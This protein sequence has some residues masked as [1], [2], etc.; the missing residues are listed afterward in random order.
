MGERLFTHVADEMTTGDDS[1]I[2]VCQIGAEVLRDIAGT[3]QEVKKLFSYVR[4]EKE[5]PKRQ[6]MEPY[7]E[8]PTRDCSTMMTSD[9]RDKQSQIRPMS[10]PP[11]VV[12]EVRESQKQ[13][14]FAFDFEGIEFYYNGESLQAFDINENHRKLGNFAV[15]ILEEKTSVEDIVNEANEV[16]ARSERLFWGI[17]IIVGEQR[18]KG[19]IFNADLYQFRWVHNISKGRAFFDE[20]KENRRLLKIY[21][22]KQI[23]AKRYQS[24]QE[25][26]S[27]G[28]KVLEN[29]KCAYLVSDGIIGDLNMSIKA[30]DK[31]CL[32]RSQETDPRRIFMEFLEMRSVI[33]GNCGNAIF[34]QYY[35]LTALMTSLFKKTGHQIEFC[36]AVIGK[37][38]TRKT[39]CAEIFTRV[40]NRT[41][42]AVPDIN[43]SATDAAVYEVMDK[44]AD[45]IV[46]IDDLT[47]SENDL[48]AREKRQKL[49]LIIRSYGDRVPRKR[50]VSYAQSNEAKEFSPITGCALLTGE[51]FS[52][53]KSS[54]SRVVI[55]RF[56]EGDVD[57]KK[58]GY[59]QENLHI[60]PDF[61]YRFLEYVTENLRRV[62]ETICCICDEIRKSNPHGLKTPRFLDAQGTL[63]AT[64]AVFY[65][66]VVENGLLNS[67]QAGELIS[68][69]KE[70]LAE[71]LMQNDAELSVISPGVVIMEAL[72]HSVQNGKI[73][74]KRKDEARHE[75]LEKS[76]FYDNEFYYIAAERLWK[77]AKRF[78]DYRRIHFPYQGSRKI[79]EPLKNEG[80]IY[81]K[82]EGKGWRSSHKICING[83]LV[84]KRF[85]W[86][87]RGIVH[88]IWNDLEDMEI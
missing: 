76:L 14:K 71:I 29:G 50:S 63:Y 85:L 42:S 74:M 33:P 30:A 15:K 49:E 10:V 58:L 24:I 51:T 28:W 40:F 36:A 32:I 44:Y 5:F 84:N 54:R 47:P 82:R 31:F 68:R 60:L 38:N 56:D 78:T 72:H 22:Q 2:N 57:T 55:L 9:V 79:I 8:N 17:E 75:E 3:D 37:T 35:L 16:I 45:Q 43:F 41:P 12:N 34:L 73:Q 88:K 23:I 25:Y 59:Y 81:R 7:L 6:S 46:L 67:E 39:S 13:R 61:V 86:L 65:S 77:C 27:S 66:F 80:I 48:D 83:E 87:K 11:I 21:L 62:E 19:T 18:F 4:E 53:G 64:S 26:T 69:D 52:G 1:T 70:R 20:T